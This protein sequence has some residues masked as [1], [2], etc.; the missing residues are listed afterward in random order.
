[1]GEH[2]DSV[3]NGVLGL[4]PSEIKELRAKGVI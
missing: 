3:L 4:S 1:L 2:T